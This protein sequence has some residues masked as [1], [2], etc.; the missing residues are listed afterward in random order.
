MSYIFDTFVM[1]DKAQYEAVIEAEKKAIGNRL[2]VYVDK[3]LL[4]PKVDIVFKNI[5]TKN[6]PE[7]KIALINFINS[8]LET[9]EEKIIDVVVINNEP[10]VD[11]ELEKASRMDVNARTANGDHINIEVQL[12]NIDD[13]ANRAIFYASK[14]LTNQSSKGISY[15]ML[16]KATSINI[17]NFTFFKE[18]RLMDVYDTC[19]TYGDIE[20]QIELSDIVKI[21]IIEL[22][23]LH[24]ILEKAKENVESLTDKEAWTIFLAYAASEDYEYLI[25]EIMKRKEGVKMAGQI[26]NEVSLDEKERARYMSHLKWLNDMYSSRDYMHKKGREEGREEIVVNLLK[27]NVDVQII[28]KVTGF[29]EE[30][31]EEL[32]RKHKN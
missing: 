28:K 22:T 21:H 31:I 12:K 26:L 30:N 19:F 10:T 9:K 24:K 6:C 16:N 20:H 32:R 3:K 5:M 15:A 14:M 13:M 27:E 7:S 25:E 1:E 2:N 8:F 11:S 29:S 17:Y 23:K 4:D 18:E